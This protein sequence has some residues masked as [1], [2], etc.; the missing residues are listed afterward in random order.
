MGPLIGNCPNQVNKNLILCAKVSENMICYLI[1][2]SNFA[3]KMILHT[4]YLPN[5]TENLGSNLGC[6]A[7][8]IYN[9]VMKLLPQM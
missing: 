9:I 2:I 6:F 4:N 5:V 1:L 8:L 3:E 7:Q